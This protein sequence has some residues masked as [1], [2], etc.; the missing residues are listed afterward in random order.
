MHKPCRVDWG[1]YVSDKTL[2]ILDDSQMTLQSVQMAVPAT[3]FTTI[4]EARNRVDALDL[5]KEHRPEFV[6]LDL[7]VPQLE[8]MDCLKSMVRGNRESKIIVIT[9]P[10][11][12]PRSIDAVKQGARSFLFKPVNREKLQSLISKLAD[13]SA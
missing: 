11:D 7:T 13:P 1:G 9:S 5:F 6:M 12:V 4:L 2:L 10:S 8:G 3:L